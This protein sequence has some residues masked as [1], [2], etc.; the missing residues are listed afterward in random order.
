MTPRPRS[1]SPRGVRGLIASMSAVALAATGL[2]ALPAA[3]AGDDGPRAHDRTFEI[4][5]IDRKALA[6]GVVAP[7][8]RE[9]TGPVTAFVKF[10]EKSAVDLAE[11]GSSRAAIRKQEQKIEDIATDLV[12]REATGRTVKGEPRRL[13]VTSNLVAGVLV[14]GDAEQVRELAEEPEVEAVYRVV[15]KKPLNKG[16]D[17]FTQ[18]LATWAS[19]GGYTGEGVRIGVIDTGVDYTHATFGGTGTV[20][21]YQEAYGEDGTGEIAWEHAD[22]AKFAGG[23]DFAGPAYDADEV[24][25][26]TPDENPIDALYF[27]ENSG[28]GT[29]VAGTAAGYG[30]DAGGATFTG[31]Y[32]DL[33]AEEVKD[34]QVGPGAAP[35]AEVY[36]LKVFGD[37]G[38]STGLVIQAL[39]WA[40]DPDDDGDFNDRLDIL[41]LSLG[42]D[43]SPADDPENLFIDRLTDLGVLSVIAS[44][45][46]G[47]L[48]DVGGSPG[49]ANSAL[50][51]ANSIGDTQTFDAI[52]VT[53]A[54]DDGLLGLHAA[55]YSVN[56]TG[57]DAVTAPVVTLPTTEPGRPFFTGCSTFDDDQAA[58]AAGKIVY[59]YWNDED[60]SLDCGSGVRFANAEAAGAVG[61]LL[62]S[63]IPV[64]SAGIAGNDTLPGAQLTG[65]ETAALQ[66]AIR[67]GGV[68]VTL[69]PAGLATALFAEEGS[70]GDLV[71]P[72]SSRGVHGSL[73]RVKPDVAAP[74]T[75]IASAGS[76]SGNG[77][78]V[79]TGTSMATPHVAGVT[80]LVRQA[81]PE[82]TPAQVK[83]AVMN[84]ATHDVWT[85]PGQGGVTWGPER[86]G[87][88][89][90]D[91]FDAVS[92]ETLVF[93]SE[94]PEGVSV[95]FGVVEVSEATVTL[96]RTVT[97]RNLSA[98]AQEYSAEYLPAVPMAGVE[99]SVLPTSIQ[100]PAGQSR[101]VTVRVTIQ[102]DLLE[103]HPEPGQEP[104]TYGL[105]VALPRDF[106]ANASGWLEV[107]PTGGKA[108][109][110]PVHVAPKPVTDVSGHDVDL[111]EA[112]RAF[113]EISGRG[114]DQ[115]GFWGLSTALQLVAESPKLERSA[116]FET[117]ESV[118]TS[119]DIRYVGFASDAP[120]WDDPSDSLV[121]VGIVTD[122]N[123]ASLGT[124]MI[125]LV[126]ADFDSDGTW[127][128]ETAIYR[129]VDGEDSLL[130]VTWEV[131]GEYPD[132]SLEWGELLD[133]YPV[134]WGTDAESGVFDNNQVVAY[135]SP[136]WVGMTPGQ[137]ASTFRVQ[138]FSPYA[139][140]ESGIIDEAVF[141][142]DVFEP[143]YLMFSAT[144]GMQFAP[145][146]D[147]ELFVVDRTD[148]TPAEGR[149]LLLHSLNASGERAEVVTVKATLPEEPVVKDASSTKLTVTPG[150]VTHGTA[151]TAKVTV[152]SKGAP[153]TGTVRITE[154]SKTLGTATVWVNGKTGKA[155]VK[156]PKNLTVGKHTL[157]ATYS[158][159]DS[160]AGSKGSATLKVTKVKTSVKLSTKSTK[161][162]KG[163]RPT[164]TVTVKSATSAKATGKVTV[165][166]G[167]KSIKASLKSGK[168]KV[169][170]PKITKKT[171]VTVSYG[172][173]S[174]HAKSK[175]SL[176]LT[177]KKK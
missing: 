149:L 127:D 120:Y 21:A 146:L 131:T 66:D 139:E 53:D 52:E 46:G 152:T 118:I 111:G 129:A 8:L 20:E 51:V 74:G 164:I 98:E 162:K 107:T 136:G 112:D 156:L 109:R 33:T 32:A 73:G 15:P 157:T 138:T 148:S 37:G 80:A 70:L 26:P 108:L 1:S 9:A 115:D 34:F 75:N 83:Q 49:N 175:A 168:A 134:S 174:T 78:W 22:P 71:N 36:A 125:P 38:G 64:F 29:H 137:G 126:A 63:Q 13:S 91:A 56:Y 84:T 158:G 153:P 170:L 40:A 172:G 119:G 85:D 10:R 68:E 171:K 159:N 150:S 88:G 169:K 102:R 96:Q 89:R 143:D 116:S 94:N 110:V 19:N 147:G 48:T 35:R 55:Q 113:L 2:T 99:F 11:Q 165:K 140:D 43:G 163:S 145:S 81:H 6:K 30:V 122:G 151:A 104:Y 50:T 57:N 39:E 72:S 103:R 100:V 76:G 176:T 41:N 95:A 47:D 177:V 45:N 87:S 142:A 155:E 97:V 82:W 117:S 90:V 5:K 135:F 4:P 16:T 124:A 167:G 154:G 58:A 44:G 123:W 77:A 114:V 69:D 27:T 7:S 14:V 101:L 24:L 86:V 106:V 144:S 161:V 121:A 160:V 79:L 105:G 12:P 128:A 166:V 141:E 28:H 67:A 17:V 3:A 65:T 133:V 92:T 31:D 62:S 173:S 61:V 23:Y 54:E 59:L 60:T 42:S 93:D 130:A 132:G 18:A 25:V